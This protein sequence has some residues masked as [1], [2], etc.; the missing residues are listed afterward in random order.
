M[1]LFHFNNWDA[2]FGTSTANNLVFQ[3][4][5]TGRMTISSTGAVSGISSLSATSITG[6]LQTAAQHN[7]TSTGDLTL[8]TSLT[9]TNGTTPLSISNTTSTSTF[10]LTIQNSGGAQDIG[11]FTSHSFL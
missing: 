11:S 2:Y 8:P 6:T 5:N 4:S 1:A 10:R 3:T 7:I 9:I